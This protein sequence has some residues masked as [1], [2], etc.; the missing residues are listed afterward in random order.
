[1]QVVPQEELR[2]RIAIK[3]QVLK[4]HKKRELG[5]VNPTTLDEVVS[6]VME[7]LNERRG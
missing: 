5:I 3:L 4:P 6:A 2:M 1:M 7:V